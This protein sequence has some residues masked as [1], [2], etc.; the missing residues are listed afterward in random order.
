MSQT[1]HTHVTHIFG[2]IQFLLF[3][4][5]RF[6][7]CSPNHQIRSFVLTELLERAG[8]NDYSIDWQVEPPHL[9]LQFA[10]LTE[11]VR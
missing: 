11:V 4:S 8:L 10:F 3:V 6:L 9:L 5:K 7:D 2:S 1:C